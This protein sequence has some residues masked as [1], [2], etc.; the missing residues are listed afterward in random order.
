MLL[1]AVT[2]ISSP[3][4]RG[5]LGHKFDVFMGKSEGCSYTKFIRQADPLLDPFP[6]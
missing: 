6:G 5:Q 3:V 2:I 1:A 4:R